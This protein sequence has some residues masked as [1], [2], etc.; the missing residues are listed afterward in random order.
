MFSVLISV[1]LL[2]CNKVGVLIDFFERHDV[3]SGFT[4]GQGSV[5]MRLTLE[6][7]GN[8]LEN[9]FFLY[10]ANQNENRFNYYFC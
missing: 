2:S 3:A 10:Q 6:Y 5:I 9:N 1:D 4:F 7:I 8:P